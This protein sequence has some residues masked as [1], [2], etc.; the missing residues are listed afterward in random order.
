MCKA[1][2]EDLC[3]LHGKNRLFI[4]FVIFPEKSE[5]IIKRNS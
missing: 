5:F 1:V 2:K 4:I 3:R